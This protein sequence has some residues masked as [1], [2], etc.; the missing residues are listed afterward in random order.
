MKLT[1]FVLAGWLFT[2]GIEWIQYDRDN[3]RD[4]YQTALDRAKQQSKPV[5][6][7]VWDDDDD[8]FLETDEAF[9][10]KSIEPYAEKLV[11]VK[12]D[13]EAQLIHDR[14][15]EAFD[16]GP[17]VFVLDPRAKDPAAAPLAKVAGKHEKGGGIQAGRLAELLKSGLERY[18]QDGQGADKPWPAGSEKAVAACLTEF[19]KAVIDG[20]SEPKGFGGSGGKGTPMYWSVQLHVG[21]AKRELSITPEGVILRLPTLVAVAD[22]PKPVAD[23]VAEAAP[24]EK[25]V[26]AERNEMRATMKYVASDKPFVQQYA[27]HVNVDGKT[28]RHVVSPDGKS[29]QTTDIPTPNKADKPEKEAEIPA[30]GAKAVAAIKKLY[31]GAVVKQITYEVFDDGTG[32]IEILTYEVEFVTDGI[33]REMVASP[34]GVIPHLWVPVEPKDLPKA[35]TDALGKSAP[36]AKVEKA[37]AFEIR[38]SLRFGALEKPKIY[39][40]VRVEKDGK[41]RTLDVKPDGIVIKKHDMQK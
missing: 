23:A 7:F 30:K 17:W 15:S 24:D 6:L 31:P 21:D 13:S 18:G 5:V 1:T 20:V 8:P 10:D 26:S 29:D 16:K 27:V 11:F 22:L 14:Y 37:L 34:E 28:A 9:K 19:P 38:A 4:P 41:V 3:V 36:D 2:G 35:V 25:I 40:T 12:I 33:E 32:D 39:Y